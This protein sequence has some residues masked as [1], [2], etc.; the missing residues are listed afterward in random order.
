MTDISRT[1]SAVWRGDLRNGR[2]DVTTGSG[3]LQ[4]IPYSVATRFE[5]QP[6][7]NPEELI[8]AAHAAC[9]AMAF[10]GVL[11]GHGFTPQA[12]QVQSTCTVSSQNGGGWKI[13]HVHLQVSGQVPGIEAAEFERLAHEADQGCP[14]S[15]LLRGG[16]STDLEIKNQIPV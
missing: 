5:N 16:V 11:A 4:N 6:G 10:S 2:G 13:S 9:F 12:L 3:V 7:S 8:A 15:N 1:S 14:I